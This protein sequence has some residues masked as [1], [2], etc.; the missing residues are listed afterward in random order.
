MDFE[1]TAEEAAFRAGG[2]E[3]AEGQ[4]PRDGARRGLDAAGLLRLRRSVRRPRGGHGSAP[5]TT[6]DGPASVAGRLRGPGRHADGAAHLPP[7]GVPLRRAL[8]P[9]RRRHR[10][11]RSDDHRPRHRRAARPLPARHAAR[12]RRVVPAVQRARR[13]VGPGQPDHPCR[14][15]T[16]TS[17][18]STARRCG[19]RAPTTPSYGHPAR[20]HRLGPAQAPG[21]HVL[22]RGHGH[23]GHR[24]A[25]AA[26]DDRRVVVQ[27]GVPHR[28]AGTGG[29]RDGRRS[30]RAGGSP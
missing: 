14:S 13:R 20:P 3:L 1:D 7:G 25:T 18:S 12:R 8:G 2:A 29:Q 10:H 24:R 5:C 19:A 16:A 30:T 23:A 28:R 26:P 17:G 6:A 4:R 22:P 27:R 21:H 9:L 11:G 15:S